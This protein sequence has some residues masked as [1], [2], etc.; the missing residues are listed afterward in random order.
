VGDM[1]REAIDGAG[2]ILD[3][4]N[5]TGLSTT[6]IQ[7]MQFVAHQTGTELDAFTDAAFK[8]G[9]NLANGEG[10]VAGAAREL[11]L[12]LGELQRMDPSRQFETIVAALGKM[13]SETE[14]NRIGVELF[15]RKFA[16]IAGAV[17][18]GLDDM[19]RQ[20]N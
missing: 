9:I 6:A 11:G 17:G 20:A 10:G 3:L 5:K 2:H 7:R 19:A 12:S 8:L 1:V 16:N 18:D 15:G 13:H 4:G 14:R